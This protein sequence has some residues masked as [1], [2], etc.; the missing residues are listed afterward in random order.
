MCCKGIK[1]SKIGLVLVFA[2]FIGGFDSNLTFRLYGVELSLSNLLGQDQPGYLGLLLLIRLV[3]A[4]PTRND[5]Y[6]LP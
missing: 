4:T 2:I 6:C 3:V 1:L 5:P